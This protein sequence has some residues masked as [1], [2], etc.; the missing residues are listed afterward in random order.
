MISFSRFF[1]HGCSL[2]LF[3]MIAFINLLILQKIF[4]LC[5][6]MQQG[7]KTAQKPLFTYPPIV[8]PF[9][10]FSVHFCIKS[11]EYG[12]IRLICVTS[13]SVIES[14]VLAFLFLLDRKGK[15]VVLRKIHIPY[16]FK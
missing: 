11:M 9:F 5:V 6:K 13:V 10:S 16:S 4:L 15:N 7:C 2:P 14:V 1:H 8:F 12:W 3:F